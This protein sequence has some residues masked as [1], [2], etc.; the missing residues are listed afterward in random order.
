MACAFFLLIN[1]L[2]KYGSIWVHF[3][4]SWYKMI[5][6]K[7]QRWNWRNEHISKTKI[8]LYHIPCHNPLVISIYTS[9]K[10]FCPYAPTRKCILY[11]TILAFL[12]WLSDLDKKLCMA[13]NQTLN[14]LG[15]RNWVKVK[16]WD[17]NTIRKTFYPLLCFTTSLDGFLTTPLLCIIASTAHFFI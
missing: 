5:N 12:C 3:A 15:F 17:D 11:K 6:L 4:S 7:V 1:W 10:G 16:C 13:F 2:I 8:D 9:L 14:N